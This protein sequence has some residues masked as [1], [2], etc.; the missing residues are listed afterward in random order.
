MII[1][2]CLTVLV[3]IVSFLFFPDRPKSKWYR[4]TPDEIFIVEERIRDNCVTPNKTIKLDHIWEALK[5][6]RLYCYFLISVLLNMVNGCISVFST[7][8]IRAMNF[9]V[10]PFSINKIHT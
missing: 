1:L 8:I 9:S 5:E 4:L 7:T 2:G 10:R 3:G 6:P